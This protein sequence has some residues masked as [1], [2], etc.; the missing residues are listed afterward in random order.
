ME[1]FSSKQRLSLALKE[2]NKCLSEYDPK[3]Y[4]ITNKDKFKFLV[5]KYKWKKK[6][7]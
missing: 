6:N 2:F 4:L 7:L 1:A 5:N 3:K